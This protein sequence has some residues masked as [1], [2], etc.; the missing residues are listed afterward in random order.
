MPDA[1]LEF[2]TL[3]VRTVTASGVNPNIVRD[4]LEAAGVPEFIE[5]QRAVLKTLNETASDEVILMAKPFQF[6]IG[7]MFDAMRK[8]IGNEDVRP[9]AVRLQ[10]YASTMRITAAGMVDA[11][12]KIEAKYGVK[13]ANTEPLRDGVR[14]YGLFADDMDKLVAGEELNPFVVEG[15][16]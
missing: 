16:V 10:E 7:S 4:V 15:E 11:A 2:D 14:L 3:V 5:W 9:L 6:D 1:Q 12:E 8:E 13:A